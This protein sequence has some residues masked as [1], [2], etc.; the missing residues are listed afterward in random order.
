MDSPETKATFAWMGKE[1]REDL[2]EYAHEA[3]SGWMK[4]MFSKGELNE[5]GTYTMPAWAVERW[6]R[7]MNAPYADLPETEKESD[8][9][10]ADKMLAIVGATMPSNVREA[11]ALALDMAEGQSGGRVPELDILHAWLDATQSD[12]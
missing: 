9:E 5:D 4:Y 7:Q 12:K 3:W 10:E 6:Q 11:I 1:L 2:A 8:R